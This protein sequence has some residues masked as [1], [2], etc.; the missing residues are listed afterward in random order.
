MVTGWWYWVLLPNPP[1]NASDCGYLM[2]ELVP[3]SN[4]KGSL[5]GVSE[6]WMVCP[7][8]E[9]TKGTSGSCVTLLEVLMFINSNQPIVGLVHHR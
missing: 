4:S 8:L 5:E 6:G 1:V 9:E 7:F 2:W 3:L